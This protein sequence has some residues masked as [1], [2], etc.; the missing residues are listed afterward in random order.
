MVRFLK[1]AALAL[2]TLA[3]FSASSFVSDA[4]AAVKKIGSGGKS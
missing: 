4:H 1:V 3:V 2:V